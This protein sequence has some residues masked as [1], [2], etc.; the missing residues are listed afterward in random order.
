MEAWQGALKSNRTT[1]QKSA[2]IV[3]TIACKPVSRPGQS[4]CRDM[5]VPF[6]MPPGQ[7]MDP[8]APEYPGPGDTA[9]A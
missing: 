5:V 2:R 4:C 3:A 7:A 9:V 6:I 8:V 1:V